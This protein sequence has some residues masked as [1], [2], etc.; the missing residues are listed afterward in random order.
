MANKDE[1]IE[2]VVD[3]VYGELDVPEVSD[4]ADWRSA[5]GRCAYSL[6]AMVPGHPWVASVLGQV[7]LAYLGPNVLRLSER[8]L[9]MFDTAGFAANETDRA[10]STVLAYVIGVATAEAAYMSMIVRSG[11]TEQEWMAGLQPSTDQAMA[12]HPRLLE[13][14]AAHRDQDPA[15]VRDENFDYGLQRVLDGLALR[16]G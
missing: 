6:R 10:M 15:R 7:G 4:P 11:Q 3:E 9:A 1:L 16:L 2:L 8:M 5:T 13:A 12:D 14:Q